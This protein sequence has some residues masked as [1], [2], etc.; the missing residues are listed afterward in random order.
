MPQ[1]EVKGK[2]ELLEKFREVGITLSTQR[3]VMKDSL[4]KGAEM[5]RS[6]VAER[7]P[8]DTGLYRKSL[9]CGVVE[10]TDNKVIVE[11]TPSRNLPHGFIGH[12]LEYGTSPHPIAKKGKKKKRTEGLHP[13]IKPQPHFR[14]VFEDVELRDRIVSEIGASVWAEIERRLI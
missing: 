10:E 11:V 7:A 1:A 6:E 14:P 4:L 8:L 5:M 13:G 9:V 12:M 2:T 3:Q